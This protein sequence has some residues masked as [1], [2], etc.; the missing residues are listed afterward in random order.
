MDFKT[1]IDEIIG[2]GFAEFKLFLDKK[3]QE[4]SDYLNQLFWL[5]D[6]SQ[7]TILN[8]LIQIYQERDE[9]IDKIDPIILMIE[10][11]LNL[12]RDKN[13]GE[14][15]HHAITSGKI[16]LAYYLLGAKKSVANGEESPQ[17]N[18]HYLFSKIRSIIKEGVE[19]FKDFFDMNRRDRGGRTLVSLALDIKDPEL[20]IHI[21]ARGANVHD[22]SNRSGAQIPFQPLHQ[23]IALNF[24]DGIRVL[25]E[26][27]AKLDNP[28]AVLRD[29]PVLLASRLGKLEALEALLEH[30]IELLALEAENK[31][32]CEETKIG[33]TAIEELCEQI[34]TNKDNALRGIAMLLCRGAE[35]PR[36]QKMQHVL[37][38]N[39]VDL[40]KAVN[41]YLEDKPALVEAFVNRCHLRESA[42][43]NI[44]YADHSW[45]SSIRHL[46]GS[47]SDA[48]LLIE[49][50]VINKYQKTTNSVSTLSP[51]DT[52]NLC[53]E[54]DPLK[55]YAE[56]VRRYNEAY[57]SQTITNR[58]STMRWLIAEGNCDWET[59]V[60]YSK[61]HPASR[62]RIVFNDMFNPRRVIHENMEEPALA[63]A[64]AEAPMQP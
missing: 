20:L 60:R 34:A 56:F 29:T 45:G 44:V 24:A 33:Y 38:R 14:P 46:F 32:Y 22:A 15:L 4:Q 43:H 21:L 37:S 9:G 1:E 16:Q 40:L 7:V 36:N 50:L 30:P 28:F 18:I 42:L 41:T 35:P 54:K 31:R 61:N 57:D 27:G 58:W 55:L 52:Q 13:L 8:Y 25:A 26:Q 48:A 5:P 64:E 23:A 11:V 17:F 6:G 59:V 49:N 19:Q 51:M 10:Y 39:R 47:P 3:I 2:S 12:S 63:P 53:E 62:T